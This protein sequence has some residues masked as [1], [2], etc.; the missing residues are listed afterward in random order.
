MNMFNILLLCILVGVIMFDVIFHHDFAQRIRR[1][2]M[3]ARR[4]QAE[5]SQLRAELQTALQQDEA[6]HSVQC[7]LRDQRIMELKAKNQELINHYEQQ[8]LDQ[9]A[10]HKITGE[11]ARKLWANE[12]AASE[13][14]A[15]E[16]AKGIYAE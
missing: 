4:A 13:I 9:E 6:R 14:G 5:C 7:L 12:K 10:K 2:E 15:S 11:I 8:L 16:T 3:K 1:A